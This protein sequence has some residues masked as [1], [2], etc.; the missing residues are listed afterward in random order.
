MC[1]SAVIRDLTEQYQP[2]MLRYARFIVRNQIDTVGIVKEAFE[3]YHAR[4]LSSPPEAAKEL[5][6]AEVLYSCEYCMRWLQYAA[7]I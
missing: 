6:Q 4:H 5:L 7:E 2:L 1:S 3:T